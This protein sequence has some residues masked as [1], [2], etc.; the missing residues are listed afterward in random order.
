MIISLSRNS[1]SFLIL[2]WVSTCESFIL[3]GSPTSYTQF[4]KWY[5]SLNGSLSF[6][7]QT[8]GLEGLLLYTDDGRMH[9]FFELKLVEGTLRLRCNL[10]GGSTLIT[11]GRALHDGEWHRVGITRNF[12]ETS[13][14]VDDEIKSS[15]TPGREFDFGNVSVNRFVYFGGLPVWYKSKLP[16]L[17]L[18]S[19][20]FEP[21]FKGAI[22]NVFYAS[23]E[24]PARKQDMIAFLGVR[25]NDMNYC[26][27]RDP[28]QHGGVCINS[29]SGTIC[30][31]K[32]LDHEG[33]FCEKDKA[34]SEATF[35][36]VEFLS[37]NFKSLGDEPIISS[38]DSV[39][40]F[41]KTRQPHG[42]LFYTG[43]GDDFLS[44]SLR[45][46]GIVLTVSLGSGSLE[47]VVRPTK[48][49]FDDNQWHKVLVHRKVRE[50]TDST[51][52]CHFSIAVDGV[53][54]QRGSTAGTFNLLYS[55]QIYVGGSNI[56][57][58]HLGTHSRISFVGCL[59]KVRFLA[60]SLNLDLIE[61]AATGTNVVRPYGNFQFACHEVEAADPIT[62][63]TKESF[64]ALSRW[65]A[66]RGGRISFKIRT[67]EP[68]GVL[69]Y[70][71]GA[72]AQG[73]FFAFELLAGHVY[74]LLNLG[75]GSVKVK[76]TTRRVDDGHWHRISL[77]RKSRS[78]RVI[79][80]EYSVEFFTQ[81][82]SN[83]LDLEGP[84]YLG[85]VGTSPEGIAIPP[86]LWS[87]KLQ[88]GYV[89]CM[90]DLV[91]ND[92]AVDI[93]LYAQK[94]DSGSI[95]PA[96]H[97]SPP[98]CDSQPCLN[99]G[100]CTEGWNR[101]ICDCSRTNFTGPVC[102]KDATTLS[103]DGEQY[104]KIQIPEISRTQAEDVRLRFRT[105]RPNGLLLAT[106]LEKS[107]SHLVVA[108]ESGSI[109]VILNLGD[110]NKVL[111]VG[112]RLNDD[113]WHTLQIIRRG[114]NLVVRADSETLSGELVGHQMTLEFQ[115][116]HIGA[117]TPSG[118]PIY[119]PQSQARDVPNF[120][121]HMQ[122]LVFNGDHYFEMARTGQL[123]NFQVTAKFG[124]KEQIVHHPVTFKSKYTFLG[125]SQLKAYSTMNLYF[126]F[127]TLEP[128]GL[129]I[130][131][132]GKEQDFIAIE[133]VDGHLDY[134]F[135][136]GDGPRKVRSNTR[137]TLNDNRW[138][139]VTIGRQS[140]RQHTLMVDDMISTVTSTGSNVHLDL[141]GLLYLGG[142]R[143]NTYNSLPKLVQS[144]HGFEG[145]LA[146]LDLNGETVDPI[147]D[148]I[149][150]STLV[151]DGCAGADTKCSNS[152]CANKGV[153]VQLWNGYTC[154]C[155]MTSFTGPT[156]SDESIAYEFGSGS[157]I[158][159]FRHSPNRSPDTKTDLLALGFITFNDR[160]VLVRI[161]SGTSNDYLQVEIME[162]N[163]FV[164]YNLGTLDHT[165]GE[166]SAR[167]DDGQHHVLRFT[168]SGPNS[169]I[170]LD[171][172]NVVTK[173][174][175]GKQLTIFNSHSKVQIGGRKDEISGRIEK[176]FHGIIAGL[177]FN[178]DRLLDMASEDDPRVTVEGDV[179]LLVSI[180]YDFGQVRT[181][182]S[183]MHQ[184]L[185]RFTHSGD[186][187]VFSGAGSGCFDDEDNCGV[188]ENESGDDLITPIFIPPTSRPRHLSTPQPPLRASPRPGEIRHSDETL[189]DDEE[190]C[191]EGSGI[192]NIVVTNPP[193]S[194]NI[195]DE[196]GRVSGEPVS[197]P[198]RVPPSSST[199]SVWNM[200]NKGDAQIN[201]WN[202]TT[203]WKPN[204]Y[205]STHNP[206]S[207]FQVPIPNVNKKD[208]DLQKPNKKPKSSADNTAL[209][210]GIFAGV[211]ISIVLI[212]LIVYKL[213]NRTDGA[214]KIDESKNYH[215]DPISNSPSLLGGQQHVNGILKSTEKGHRAPKKKDVKDLKE[216][217]V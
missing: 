180:P 100:F 97:T 91:V 41:F 75:S 95:R 151:S 213:R 203:T 107:V 78:G 150:P 55:K 154:D 183:Q 114:H 59:R 156:C 201:A 89:G 42:M 33:S 200:V 43:D 28:C 140:L 207:V 93:A 63:T 134:I 62:F 39:S 72:T 120:V 139:A 184:P 209:V 70:N 4:K 198:P 76:A 11:V 137:R 188:L 138:H 170:Q 58:G 46:G 173:Y 51:S 116:L 125:I 145:C 190:G 79:V 152:A 77:T 164:V 126:Q 195:P 147:T 123:I 22:R 9:H 144:K 187:L 3:E 90:R 165:I 196:T 202:L 84:L 18:P 148:A 94:Q 19:A 81:G 99:G 49:R 185:S 83:Q 158:I 44:L 60:D 181:L 172:H 159:T 8:S 153:C 217:Y 29:D 192:E 5:I 163:I 54:T 214:Y 177:V 64:L 176:P 53:Y 10:G 66:P 36:G 141:H 15:L 37:Y 124:K 210:I 206:P 167:V 115:D 155:D 71:S 118:I 65:D 7:F 74:L 24:G 85:G 174:P 135:N 179:E 104:M 199:T 106:T 32:N 168:R 182:S 175:D 133:L 23:D 14:R 98:Q 68:N 96:C 166:L 20:F 13:L 38:S 157:G 162:G 92:N 216:W 208:Q 143:R 130:Y 169:T 88:Y 149:I 25:N 50:I 86:E 61:L 67:N 45:G 87:G 30:D 101:Y 189:C 132:N 211:L 80:D 57:S 161:D 12:E 186:D 6:E 160:A 191:G 117:Y 102:A 48:V 31:C 193:F 52:F 111:H 35:R 34:P 27:H 82:N 215:F 109:K 146:S 142:V 26:N 119:S 178:G 108:L 122:Q 40:L 136:L 1:I 197:D 17:A 204:G 21:R 112:H 105:T 113:Q 128:N 127:K 205:I 171:D 16:Q 194:Y 110:G 131:N 69:M 47:R 56:T 212:A 121:G 103:F 2:L 73:D 129:I